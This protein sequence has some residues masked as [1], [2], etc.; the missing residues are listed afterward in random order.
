MT[1]YSLPSTQSRCRTLRLVQR[2][3]LMLTRPSMTSSESLGERCYRVGLL[4]GAAGRGCWAGLLGGAAGW[5]CY[6]G[7]GSYTVYRHCHFTLAHCTNKVVQQ[8]GD[9]TS[10]Q[11]CHVC[12]LYMEGKVLKCLSVR[13]L[14]CICRC[15][16]VCVLYN[17]MH[18]V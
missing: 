3:D 2:T 18:R 9:V 1:K 4:G 11:S 17:Y 7:V 10:A 16:C 5:G 14:L 12:I 13:S 8:S 15:T 6:G